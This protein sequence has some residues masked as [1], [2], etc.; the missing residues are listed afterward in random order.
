MGDWLWARSKPLQLAQLLCF[1]LW[2]LTLIGA[3][4][5]SPQSELGAWCQTWWWIGFLLA[6]L[7]MLAIRAMDALLGRHG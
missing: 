3:M 5:L 2:L 4:V 1:L 7:A 6:L